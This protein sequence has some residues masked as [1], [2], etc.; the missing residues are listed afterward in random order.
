MAS[1]AAGEGKGMTMMALTPQAK[2]WIMLGVTL[3]AAL[4]LAMMLLGR[5]AF[6]GNDA[7]LPGFDEQVPAVARLRIAGP[8]GAVE[9]ARTKDGSW[10]LAS[11]GNAPARAEMVDQVLDAVASAGIVAAQP[12]DL[13]AMTSGLDAGV[14]VTVRDAGGKVLA[15]LTIGKPAGDDQVYA[16]VEGAS[17][18]VI[19]SGLP[20]LA[21]EA[22][23]WT[24]LRLP[25]I[26]PERIKSVRV[27]HADGDIAAFAR[28]LAGQPFQLT[29]GDAARANPAAIEQS[30][31]VYGDLSFT[32]LAS[33]RDISWPGASMIFV[34]T[35]DGLVVTLLAKPA[36]AVSQVRINAHF[37]APLGLAAEAK[38]RGEAEAHAIN[39]LRAYAFTLPAA[40][41]AVLNRRGMALLRD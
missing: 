39:D 1:L 10:V 36:G 3:A 15:A 7:L 12:K 14:Q 27:L 4:V 11:A 28:G 30:A 22:A 16:R 23:R 20:A 21:L 34:E 40:Q 17:A 18:P 31:R 41:A 9:L 32:G 2:R 29:S 8:P 37:V 33:A 35:F 19:A 25:A 26:A 13:P 38:T 5:G 24:T 6:S